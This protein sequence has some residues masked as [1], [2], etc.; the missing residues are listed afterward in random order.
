MKYQATINT[1]NKNNSHTQAF[2]K[3]Q[4][5]ANGR[6]LRILEVGCSTGYFGGA[7]VDQG[8]E[9][10]GVEPYEE[11]AKKASE[12]LHRVH[13]GFIE[14]FF[15]SNQD[16]RF[17][18]IVFGDVL[19]H[20]TDPVGVL[21]QSMKF[22]ADGGVVVASVPN[23]A[24][25]SIRAMMLE[26]RWEYSDLGILDRTHLKFFT[27][28]SLVDLFNES[29]YKVLSLSAVRLSAEQVDEICKLNIRKESIKCVKDFSTD[30]R[31]Y[32][33]QYVVSSCPCEDTEDR[34]TVNSRLKAED[35]LRVLCL[36]HDP[37]SSIVEIRLRR[38]ISRWAAINGG[39]V[40]I[41]SIYDFE[42]ANLSWADVVVFQ[43]DGSEYIVGLAEYL[44]KLGKK[45]V[46]EI[47]D[48]LTEL[49]PFL[50]HHSAAVDKALPYIR[51][52]LA[53]ADALSVSSEVLSH[54]FRSENN[55]IFVTPNFS[56]QVNKVASHFQVPP[57]DVRL[58]IASSDKVLVDVLVDPLRNLQNKYG[59]Q[60]IVIGPPGDRLEDCSLDIVRKPNLSHAEF[61]MFIAS[62]DNGIG[63]IPLDS[64][65][66]SGC[67]TAVKYFDY[68]MC[69]I[70]S[71]CSNVL[72]YLPVVEDGHSGLLVNND[73]DGW[74]RAIESLLIS[75]ELRCELA[76]NARANVIRYHSIDISAN[77]WSELLD[78]LGINASNRTSEELS[79]P[80]IKRSGFALVRT[81]VPHLIRPSSYAKV[82]K[83]FFRFGLRGLYERVLR[84]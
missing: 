52:L 50:S 80:S 81:L 29:G 2:D 5:F 62:I 35:G 65:E 74:A 41:L 30:S 6:A 70:P 15:I 82:F 27:R 78:S 64:S 21:R 72:P 23:I 28:N 42:S 43:R 48:L 84:R 37:S 68:S 24:H 20:L 4:E 36:V 67:K 83:I 19:E 9:V 31:G 60:V 58:V 56:E 22:I 79:I 18:V 49:P 14:D 13:I 1:S 69:G 59:F 3:I 44:Q 66:F 39:H 38:P 12:I 33:F 53:S 26:G 17:D 54:K 63:L 61:K 10:W 40:E 7:L 71:I 34:M 55:N 76:E 75:H 57:S 46:F 32:D 8:H 25:F 11:A 47:D 16:E 45:V 51:K 73:F 77:A